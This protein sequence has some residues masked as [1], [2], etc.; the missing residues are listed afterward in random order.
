[1]ICYSKIMGKVYEIGICKNKGDKIL[2]INEVKAIAGNGLVNDRKSKENNTKLSQITLIEI[3]NINYYNKISNSSI[4]P[5]DFRRNI[6]TEDIRLNSLV[7][8]EFF[9][10]NVK[11]KG[12]DL[13]RPCKYLEK[14]L[15][16]KNFIKELL[17]KGGLRCEILLSGK[18]VKGD[19]IKY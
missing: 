3:E 19:R 17:Y 4:Q 5:V 9:V 14:L 13:C 10:G 12:H 2:K 11:L 6:I 8:K 1:M 18:I 16:Q 15:S 7:G